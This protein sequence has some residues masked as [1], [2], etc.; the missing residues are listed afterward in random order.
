MAT[1]AA[2]EDNLVQDP[3]VRREHPPDDALGPERNRVTATLSGWHYSK[4]GAASRSGWWET[5]QL[6]TLEIDTAHRFRR[7]D[8]VSYQRSLKPA[9]AE[10]V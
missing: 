6:S 1:S 4:F 7:D 9:A 3:Q 5:A 10:A 8:Q 2:G